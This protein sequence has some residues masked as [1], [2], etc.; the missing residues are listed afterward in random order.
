MSDKKSKTV[1]TDC[2]SLKI[3]KLLTPNSLLFMV[4]ELPS[5]AKVPLGQIICEKMANELDLEGPLQLT[6]QTEG[7]IEKRDVH[8]KG[9]NKK[10][11]NTKIVLESYKKNTNVSKNLSKDKHGKKGHKSKDHSSKKIENTKGVLLNISKS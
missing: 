2:I 10:N 8:E 3:L 6:P 1:S 9:A 4:K 7:L 11:I 5:K